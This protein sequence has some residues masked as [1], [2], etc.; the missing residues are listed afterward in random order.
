MLFLALDTATPAGS[1]ALLTEERLL[2][3][4]Y[5]DVGLHHSQRLFIEID[6]VFRRSQRAVAELDAVA[7]TIGPG[8]FTGLRIGLS[9]AKGLCLAHGS[10]LVTVPTLEAVAGRLPFSRHPICAMLDARRGEVYAGLYDTSAGLPTVLELPRAVDPRSM[11]EELRHTEVIFAGDGAT[12]H[13]E[14]LSDLPLAIRAPMSCDRPDAAT[15]G[16][17]GLARYHRGEVS[18]LAAV[19]PEY[20]RHPSYRRTPARRA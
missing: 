1:V 3:S 7:V 13:D 4:R 11:V 19:E 8:S 20:L 17:L 5:F 14:L 6:A 18:D 12:A 16:W 15:T 10:S 2:E 9:A